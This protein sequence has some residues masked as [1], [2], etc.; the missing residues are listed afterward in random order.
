MKPK[1]SLS[2]RQ[3]FYVL[4]RVG[5]KGPGRT[6]TISIS[7]AQKCLNMTDIFSSIIALIDTSP[8]QVDPKIVIFLVAVLH[9]NAKMPHEKTVICRACCLKTH[10]T[11]DS[12]CNITFTL[13]YVSVMQPELFVNKS[14]ILSVLYLV[15]FSVEYS[16]EYSIH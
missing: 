14:I 7:I 3:P 6:S 4:S 2:N 11:E 5:H 12:W 15:C 16:V 10:F 13:I 9:E 1:P 8:D